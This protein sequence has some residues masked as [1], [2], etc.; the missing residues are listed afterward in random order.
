MP[1]LSPGPPGRPAPDARRLRQTARSFGTDA[2]RYDRSRP[3]YPQ[4]LVDRLAAPTPTPTPTSTSTPTPTSTPTGTASGSGGPLVLDVGCGTG[5]VARQFRDVGCRVVGVE[6][7]PRMA[8]LARGAGVDVEVADFESWDPAGRR[9]DAVVSGQTW[10]WLDAAAAATVA[11]RALL[12]GGRLAVFWNVP[13]LPPEVTRALAAACLRVAPD[14]P[15]RLGDPTSRAADGYQLLL[16]AAADGIRATGD[17]DAPERW[18]HDWQHTYTR[19]AWLDQLPTHGALTRL[20]P[21]QVQ[22]I[23]TEVGAAIDAL[24]GRFTAAYATLTVTAT[25]RARRGIG[26]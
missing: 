26:G 4:P 22:Q 23:L 7:D 13:E 20:A 6:V 1:T 12:P 3:R 17:F 19:D 21:E 18:R 14:S 2:A 10:H 9:F 25:R 15:F 8:G 24:G 16:D 5:I 11:A